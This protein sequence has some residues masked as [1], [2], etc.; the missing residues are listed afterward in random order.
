MRCGN[1]SPGPTGRI[2]PPSQRLDELVQEARGGSRE[3]LEQL[4][5]T[6]RRYLLLIARQEL[7]T[8]VQAKLSAS[9]AVQETL[10]K[11][12]QGFGGFAGHSHREWL[13]WVRTILLRN[14]ADGQRRYFQASQRDVRRE[15]SLDDSQ[16]MPAGA[17]LPA[18]DPSPSADAMSR[19]ARDR[20]DQAIA[21]LPE[22]SRTVV[23]LHHRD[24]L[25]FEEIAEALG[26]TVHATRKMWC[27]AIQ[28]LAH[29]LDA[30]DEPQRR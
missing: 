7:P 24:A 13:G 23:L 12:V 3:A 21:T 15:I 5:Q 19:E 29:H 26:T 8:D 14:L 11:A 28:Q 25:P 2:W 22:R 6:C 30:D 9:D 27:R 20:I 18:Q 1:D 4:V 16:L 10:V 17:G